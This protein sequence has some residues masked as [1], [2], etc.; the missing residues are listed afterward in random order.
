MDNLTIICIF[1]VLDSIY[2]ISPEKFNYPSFMVS[3][4][5]PFKDS[6]NELIESK[7][8]KKN[9][10]CGFLG[11]AFIPVQGA[12]SQPLP[13]WQKPCPCLPCYKQQF[14]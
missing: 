2:V 11:C 13:Y 4:F 1:L 8:F 5:V 12:I 10:D 9:Q 14:R 3:I 6:A 7:C